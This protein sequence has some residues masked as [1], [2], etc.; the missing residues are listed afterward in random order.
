M[1][2]E[3]TAVDGTTIVAGTELGLADDATNDARI[4]AELATRTGDVNEMAEEMMDDDCAWEVA[5]VESDPIDVASLES[6]LSDETEDEDFGQATIFHLQV[7]A[8][9][10]THVSVVAPV[11]VSHSSPTACVTMLSPHRTLV[12]FFVQFG[13]MPFLVDSSH[14]SPELTMPL[15][16]SADVCARK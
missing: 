9:V 8:Q 16:Q 5:K 13:P 6:E 2:E 14:S 7:E 10:F 3:T 4:G 12:Q 15:P 11:P 1:Y